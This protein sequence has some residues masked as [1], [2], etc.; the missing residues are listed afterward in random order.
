MDADCGGRFKN[1]ARHAPVVAHLT[2]QSVAA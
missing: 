2:K 1:R